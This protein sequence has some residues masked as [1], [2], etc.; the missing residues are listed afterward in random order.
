[1]V[2]HTPDR[3]SVDARSITLHVTSAPSPAQLA[4]TPEAVLGSAFTDAFWTPDVNLSLLS[5][6]LAGCTFF[7]GGLLFRDS[8]LYLAIQCSKFTATGPDV[9]NEFVVV[10][11]TPATGAPTTWRWSYRGKLATHAD[12]VALG[13]RT[14]LQTDLAYG[15]N[16][17]LLAIFSPSDVNAGTNNSHLAQHFG[18]RAVPVVSLDMP[19]LARDSAGSPVVLASVTGSDLVPPNGT[20]AAC[21][22]DPASSTG[23][24]LARRD[25]RNGLRSAIHRTGLKP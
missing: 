2:Y 12:A 18:C 23:L 11:S 5:S 21:G 14:L 20:P 25:D 7:D 9:A 13:G 8:T 16:G 4:T 19:A 6:D 3:G 10:F 22:Y 1:M 15:Q 17:T 24:L